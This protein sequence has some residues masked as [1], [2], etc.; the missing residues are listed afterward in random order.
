MEKVKET[1]SSLPW[2]T[3]RWRLVNLSRQGFWLAC[4]LFGGGWGGGGGGSC[5]MRVW[6]PT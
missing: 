5:S 1:T 4:P 2:K 6:A 3:G